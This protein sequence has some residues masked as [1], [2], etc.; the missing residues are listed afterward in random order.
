MV[1]SGRPLRSVSTAEGPLRRAESA[2]AS[3]DASGP[4]FSSL[5]LYAQKRA[6]SSRSQIPPSAEPCPKGPREQHNASARPLLQH[7]ELQPGS[8]SPHTDPQAHASSAMYTNVSWSRRWQPSGAGL[9]KRPS[10]GE[11]PPAQPQVR[12]RH[13]PWR[14]RSWRHRQHRQDRPGDHRH[15]RQRGNSHQSTASGTITLS[16]RNP[17]M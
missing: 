4:S 3:V 14:H 2:S 13:R 6:T 17:P 10:T 1:V 11:M 8:S 5:K 9:A 15:R 12:R 7:P 16:S